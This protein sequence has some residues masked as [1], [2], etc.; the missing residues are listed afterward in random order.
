MVA[1]RPR[2]AR[3]TTVSKRSSSCA[4]RRAGVGELIDVVDAGDRV[5]VIMRPLSEEARQVALSAN[6]TTFRDGGSPGAA[7]HALLDRPLA[8]RATLVGTTF[9]ECRVTA[10]EVGHREAVMTRGN[11]L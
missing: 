6:L 4:R 7:Q 3:A 11:R 8:E 1:T 5:I 10:L 9:A 2:R